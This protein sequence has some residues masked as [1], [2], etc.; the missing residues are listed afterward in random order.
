M[1]IL[2]LGDFAIEK[3]LLQL[4]FRASQTTRGDKKQKVMKWHNF[5][6]FKYL[7]RDANWKDQ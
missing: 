1:M 2:V 7:T 5:N 4:R 3:R 6:M